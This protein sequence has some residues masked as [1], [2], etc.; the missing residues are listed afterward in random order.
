MNITAI[1]T[2]LST[3]VADTDLDGDAVL[4]LSFGSVAEVLRILSG[5]L[6]TVAADTIVTNIAGVFLT[7]AQRDALVAAQSAS[8]DHSSTGSFSQETRSS[9]DNA[10]TALSARSGQLATLK[11]ASFEYLGVAGAAVAVYDDDGNVL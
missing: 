2:A 6:Y 1:N 7:E 11:D 8:A 4:S 5:D 9:A 3:I 10:S